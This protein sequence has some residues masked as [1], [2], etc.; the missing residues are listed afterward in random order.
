M[1]RLSNLVCVVELGVRFWM[2]LV[3]LCAPEPHGGP[4]RVIIGPN[5]SIVCG[6]RV[7]CGVLR[8]R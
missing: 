2:H 3:G 7:S 8:I 6:C 4:S 1:G 5:Q